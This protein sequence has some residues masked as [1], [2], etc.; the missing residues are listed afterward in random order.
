[1][2]VSSLLLATAVIL[3]SGSL[4]GQAPPVTYLG[5]YADEG[6]MTWCANG[7]PFYQIDL[8]VYAVLGEGGI[9]AYNF[10][11]SYPVCVEVVS[12]STNGAPWQPPDQCLPGYC[13]PPAGLYGEFIKCRTPQEAAVVWL[14]HG[15]LNVISPD[16]GIVSLVPAQDKMHPPVFQTNAC[17]G[18][19]E[20]PRILSNLY[21]NYD[22][23]APECSG[24]AVNLKTWGAI[25][26]LYR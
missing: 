1:M 23:S 2:K 8:W 17:G 22:P 3:A 24:M 14:V 25:K 9:A 12:L 18:G 4:F 26:Q 13:W 5:L 16:Q 7:T 19:V 6:R 21:V 11:L 20:T 10:D 15:T